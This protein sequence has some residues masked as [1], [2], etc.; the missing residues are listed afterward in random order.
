MAAWNPSPP[1]QREDTT[2][3]TEYLNCGICEEPYDED[4]HQAKFLTCYHTFC[5]H[6][7]TEL[8]K[9]QDNPGAITCPNCRHSTQL[10]SAWVAGLQRNFYIDNMK[11]ITKKIEPQMEDN[12]HKHRKQPRFFFC[13][14]CKMAICRDCTVLDHSITAGH[15]IF[16]V[17][18]AEVSHRQAL[19]QQMNEMRISL[20]QIQGDIEKLNHEMALLIKT[21]K[22]TTEDIEKFIQNIYKKVE[23]RKQQLTEMNEQTFCDAQNFL[24]SIQ[25]PLQETID[26]VNKKLDQCECIVKNGSLNEVISIN[27]KLKS[28]ARKMQSGFAE[29]NFGK[30]CMSLNPNTGIEDFENIMCHLAKI[31]FKGFLPTQF[32]F[33]CTEAKAGQKAEM[34]VKLSSNQGEPVPCPFKEFTVEITDP[35]GT[36]LPSD[37]N[38]N[39]CVYTVTFT[40]QMSGLH[41]V[42][43]IFLGKQL[44]NEQTQIL[45]SSN[46]PVLKFGKEGNGKGALSSPWSIAIDN[47]NHLYVTD[48]GNRLIQ[49]FTADGTFL[50]QFST[51]VHHKDYVTVDMALDLNRGLLFC[52]EISDENHTL[53]KGENILVFNLEGEIQHTYTPGNIKNAYFIAMDMQGD[54]I[55]SDRG[56]D[57]LSKVDRE[58][59]FLGHIA[60]LKAPTFIAITDDDNIIVPDRDTDTIYIFN[61]NGTV[62]L[63]FGSSGSKKGQFKKPWGVAIDGEYILVGE[64]ENNRVQIFKY[65]GTFVSMIESK[66]DPLSEP[67]GLAVTT[68]GHVYVADRNNRCVKKFKYKNMP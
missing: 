20:A 11:G 43:G 57:C 51:A 27:H 55:L 8:T 22:T 36:K 59:N 56:K 4:N 47:D 52:M 7:L 44:T 21:K 5:S 23:K 38:T 28:T 6:C 14:T 67:R 15:V 50:S 41:K 65:D 61:S 54:F 58:G 29:F 19:T 9:K 62:K 30:T 12:C 39:G 16:D 35:E 2:N 42:S 49:K 63:Q 40:P 17:A 18:D 34:Q 24:L 10:P 37:Q 48:V 33:K 13:D 31:D 68:D 46:N 25:T 1:K 26:M 53:V 66:E 32:E 3:E 45:V 60:D 64:G